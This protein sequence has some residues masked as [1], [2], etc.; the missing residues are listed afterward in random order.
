MR[1]FFPN[2]MRQVEPIQ[3]AWF[4]RVDV[5]R[6]GEQSQWYCPKR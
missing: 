6:I 3:G 2:S 1:M 4:F 5:D